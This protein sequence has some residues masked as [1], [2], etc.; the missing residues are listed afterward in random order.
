MDFGASRNILRIHSSTGPLI[1]SPSSSAAHS[2]GSGTVQES[3]IRN[4]S[5]EILLLYPETIIFV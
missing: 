5:E 4:P 3:G 1:I 2:T